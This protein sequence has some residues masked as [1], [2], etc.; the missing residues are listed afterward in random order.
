MR[1]LARP[2]CL[3]VPDAPA[4]VLFINLLT[5]YDAILLPTLAKK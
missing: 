1:A 2:A 5:Y 4:A 3:L